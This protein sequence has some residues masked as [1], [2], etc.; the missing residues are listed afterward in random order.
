MSPTSPLLRHGAAALLASCALLAGCAPAVHLPTPDIAMPAAFE[1]HGATARADAAGQSPLTLDRWWN[2]FSD[3]QLGILIDGALQ[4]SPTA[5]L[6]YARLKEARATRRGTVAGTGPTGGLTGSATEQ[7]SRHLWGNGASTPGQ[8][9]YQANVYPSWEIDIFGRLDMIRDRADLTYQ[10]SALDYEGVRLALAADIATSLF[11]AR[12][13]HAQLETARET[14]RIATDL[15]RTARIGLARGL[16]SGQDAAR[17]DADVSSAQAEVARLE[18]ELTVAKRLL[19]IL[20]GTPYAATDGLDISASLG[21]PPPLPDATPGSLLT[22]RPDV[23]AAGIGVQAAGLTARIDRLALFP[24]FTIQPGIGLSA[25][26]SSSPLPSGTGLWSL[27]AGLTLPILDR[28]RLLAAMRVSEA[29]GEQAVITYEQTIQTAYGEAE[30]ALT[31]VAADARRA[32]DL[33]RAAEQAANAL[34]IARQGYAAG[35]TD[36]TTL[37]QIQRSW[38]QARNARDAARYAHLADSVAAIRAMGGGWAADRAG[39]VAAQ[40]TQT[41]E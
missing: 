7:G 35:L 2:G 29:R 16:T 28:P 23:I 20:I 17:L 31:R 26:G 3:G 27:A 32:A 10:S 22:R 36:L 18:S 13:I 12:Y 41:S 38:L 8:Q 11:Q 34:R 24:Q 25:T 9:S 30:N 39:D 19:L 1:P 37:L 5:R 6:A 21:P 33:T 14:G 40:I 15:A 4:R